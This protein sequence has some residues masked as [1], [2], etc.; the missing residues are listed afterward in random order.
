M[1]VIV[2]SGP[3]CSG[4]TEFAIKT[5]IENGAEIISCDSVQVY[6]G[7]DIGSAKASPQDMERVRHHLIDVA[8][9]SE[10]FDVA[11]YVELAKKALSD[12]AKRGKNAV[13]VGGSGFYLK[14]W[15]CAVA[16]E[17]DVSQEIK[18]RCQRLAAEGAQALAQELLK[19]SPDARGLIDLNNPRRTQNALQRCLATGKSVSELLDRFSKLPCPYGDLTPEFFLIDRPDAEMSQRI[20]LRTKSMLES[21]LV[22]E[23]RGLIRLGIKSNPAARNAIGY[24]QAISYIESG[25]GDIES[26]ADEIEIQTMSLVRRQRKFFRTQKVFQKY[27]TPVKSGGATEPL[28]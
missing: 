6:R 17:I 22:E 1:R 4:K 8:D 14:S 28:V 24:K 25:C 7:M 10:K 5:A 3:T 27:I 11:N 23:T 15:F 13:V 26:L 19:I 18:L 12:I 16:D 9:V 21:G 2:I 20:K